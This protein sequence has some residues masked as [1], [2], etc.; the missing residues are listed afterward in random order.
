M[1]VAKISWR[2]L[3]N[4]KYPPRASGLPCLLGS[5]NVD[6]D[7]LSKEEELPAQSSSSDSSATIPPSAACASLH[8]LP[9]S[10]YGVSDLGH[11]PPLPEIFA[12]LVD[13]RTQTSATKPQVL[14]SVLFT[15]VT[16]GT[17]NGDIT[18]HTLSL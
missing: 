15:L 7:Q 4:N 3:I 16:P 13:R 10:H 9:I 12:K 11:M 18:K 1:D 17:H 2:N 8:G 6:N 5:L 14:G